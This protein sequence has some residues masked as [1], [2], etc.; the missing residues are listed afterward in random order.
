MISGV[1]RTLHRE[2][3]K[4]AR[5]ANAR[6]GQ[7]G[8]DAR[9]ARDIWALY[10]FCCLQ[11][12]WG[13]ELGVACYREDI[14]L[15]RWSARHVR[16]TSLSLGAFFQSKCLKFLFSRSLPGPSAAPT[17]IV[18]FLECHYMPM[19]WSKRSLSHVCSP[20][21][22]CF[23][24]VSPLSSFCAQNCSA[25]RVYSAFPSLSDIFGNLKSMIWIAGCI[26]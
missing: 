12:D 18:S 16:K 8:H 20:F 13:R 4:W 11:R 1:R 26:N 10:Y 25:S 19:S 2:V 3:R 5:D 9:G 21:S 23:Y 7:C 24:F 22:A 6:R 17:G 15:L 14:F